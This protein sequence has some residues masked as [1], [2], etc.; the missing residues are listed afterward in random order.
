MISQIFL[1]ATLVMVIV[2]LILADIQKF[3]A[4]KHNSI[5]QDSLRKKQLLLQFDTNKNGSIDENEQAHAKLNSFS[6]LYAK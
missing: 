4:A 3:G 2:F 5:E 6:I 1:A